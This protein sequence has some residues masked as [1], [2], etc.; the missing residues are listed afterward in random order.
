MHEA[1]IAL[2]GCKILIYL[3]MD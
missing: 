2:D 3:I 1:R